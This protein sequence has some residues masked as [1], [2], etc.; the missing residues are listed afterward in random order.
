MSADVQAAL[1]I[2]AVIMLL[3]GFAG[4]VFGDD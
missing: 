2:L 4:A 3:L 1:T